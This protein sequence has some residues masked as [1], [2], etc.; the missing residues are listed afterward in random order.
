MCEVTRDLSRPRPDCHLRL[1]LGLPFFAA[2]L[3]ASGLI[4]LA[5][6]AGAIE[7]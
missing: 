1:S 5:S 3:F 4:V 2:A 7:I 6:I